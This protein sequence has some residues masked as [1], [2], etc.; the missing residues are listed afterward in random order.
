MADTLK[1]SALEYHRL[2]QPGKLAVVATKP[3]G[4]QRDL[5]LAY[6]PGVAA[7]CEAIV[8]DP[9]QATAVTARGN[10]VAVVTNGTAVLGLGAIGPL[11]AK[12]VM[13]GKAVL[14]KKF[15]GIDVFDLEIDEADPE[16]LVGIV[17]S[18]EPSFGAINLEDI[19]A[20]DCF[21]VEDALR[22]RMNIPVFHDDQ[23]GTAIITAAAILNALKVTGKKLNKVKLVTSGA[24]AAAIA[25]LDL[26][27]SMGLPIENITATDI[28]GVLYQGRKED[29]GPRRA[30]YAKDTKARTLKEVIPGAD[31]FLGLSAGGV[32]KPDYLKKMA[33]RPLI[34]ALANPTPEIMPD[35]AK[36]IRPDAII[37]TGRSDFPNQVNNVLCFP[38]LFRGALDVSATAINEEMKMA[39]VRAI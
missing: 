25:C 7:A 30:K 6:S 28:H 26:L 24:G 31:I 13:E 9:A 27:V 22:E 37:G 16:K 10:L 33:K 21:I 8:E 38:F 20:P 17:A 3:L 23:H 19:R 15:A 36:E 34:M 5:A 12:P 11:A 18:L 39:A 4:T 35:L 32:L 2:P 29:M 14:F 1:D